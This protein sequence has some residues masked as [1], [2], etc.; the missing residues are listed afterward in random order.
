[1]LTENIYQVFLASSVLTMF[2]TPFLMLLAYPSAVMLQRWFGA[3]SESEDQPVDEGLKNHVVIVGF[4]LNGRNVAR[5]LKAVGIPFIVVELND[6]LVQEARRQDIPV[7]FGDATRTEVLSKA[8]VETAHQVVVA[9]SDA[10]ATRHCVAV[11]RSMNSSVVII[12]RTRY[13]SEVD[14][15]KQVGANIVIPEEFETSVEIFS[16][17]LE[18]Y[19]IPD[20]LIDQQISVVR[21][22][23]YGM[24]RGLSLSAERLMKISELFLKSTIQQVVIGGDSPVKDLTIRQI[25]LRKDTGA[26][27]IAV[28]RGEEVFTNP[29]PEFQLRENDL[30]VLW[31]AHQQLAAAAKRLNSHPA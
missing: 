3:R 15:L 9:I 16:R 20:H 2:M 13:V 14:F 5:V 10:A 8:R 6:K 12:V 23:S 22:G 28:V 24:L 18:Q 1:M 30:L 11:A 25:N 19:N 26:S 21:A 17:V 4:G 7:L 29:S 27:I 31:G